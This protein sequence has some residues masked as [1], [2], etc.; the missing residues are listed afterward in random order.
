MLLLAIGALL[1]SCSNAQEPRSSL[2]EFSKPNVTLSEEFSLKL[3]RAKSIP[4]R[5]VRK[6]VDSGQY[7]FDSFILDVE[8]KNLAPH[9]NLWV[10]ERK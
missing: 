3:T 8:F 4:H 1:G 5:V 7:F 9:R 2:L 6:T 10:A